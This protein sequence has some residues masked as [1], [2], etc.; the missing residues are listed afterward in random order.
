MYSKK[1]YQ[2]TADALNTSHTHTE[3]GKMLLSEKK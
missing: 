3:K 2:N 1:T